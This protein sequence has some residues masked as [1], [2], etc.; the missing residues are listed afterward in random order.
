[1]DAAASRDEIAG[2]LETDGCLIVRDLIDRGC[3]ERLLGDLE[4]YLARTPKGEGRALDEYRAE[5]TEVMEPYVWYPQRAGR[6]D[7]PAPESLPRAELER[8]LPPGA[9]GQG[10]ALLVDPLPHRG[11]DQILAAEDRSGRPPRRR[12]VVAL[13]AALEATDGG[14]EALY[15]R[16]VARE[17]DPYTEADQLLEAVV[18]VLR[19]QKEEEA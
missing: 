1:M 11:L 3:I 13:E 12:L 17:T 5:L 4:P 15:E 2:L 16:L 14:A 8:L 19:G 10:L 9:V 7:L 6:P 18:E